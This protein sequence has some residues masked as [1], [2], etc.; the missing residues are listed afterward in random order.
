MTQIISV[1]Q[2]LDNGTYSVHNAPKI[3]YMKYDGIYVNKNGTNPDEIECFEKFDWERDRFRTYKLKAD[4]GGDWELSIS[5]VK[6]IHFDTRDKYDAQFTVGFPKQF[7][8]TDYCYERIS[9]KKAMKLINVSIS[10]NMNYYR[11]NVD[12]MEKDLNRTLDRAD[13]YSKCKMKKIEAE[14]FYNQ[15]L[16][17]FGE[18]DVEGDSKLFMINEFKINYFDGN[19]WIATAR[20]GNYYF[21]FSYDT[22]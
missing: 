22:S 5:K 6:V 14:L 11:G 2:K 8:R 12:E 3:M 7:C 19:L 4:S 18:D 10:I 21:K 9:I 15:M 20:R 13:L 17:V 1:K 16:K